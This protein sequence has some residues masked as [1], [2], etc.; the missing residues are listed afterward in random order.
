MIT[1]QQLKLLR[2][3]NHKPRTVS[4]LKKKYQVDDPRAILSGMYT[5]IRSSDSR[6]PDNAVL[7]ITKAGLI[8]LESHEWFDLQY[9]VT[10]ILVPIIIGVASA[11]ITN[12][13]LALL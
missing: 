1:K 4:W 3:I 7:T 9:V 12:A 8:E 10:N 13:L 2:K 6:F 11:V 5:L